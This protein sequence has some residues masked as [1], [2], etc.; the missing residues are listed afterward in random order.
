ML[1]HM[2]QSVRGLLH[3][4]DREL[5]QALRWVTHDNGQ[6]FLTPQA[7]R[8]ALMDELA[9]GHEL[10]R[11]GPCEGFDPKRGCPGHKD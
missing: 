9:N 7:L 4:S 6:H 10:I 11:T 5:R 1:Y 3:Y 2:A 8:E